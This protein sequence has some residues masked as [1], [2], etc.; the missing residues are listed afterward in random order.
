MPYNELQSIKNYRQNDIWSGIPAKTDVENQ[1]WYQVVKAIDIR[2]S[3]VQKSCENLVG[4]IGYACDEGVRRNNG[5]VGAVDGPEAIRERLAHLAFH[6]DGKSIADYGDIT[7]L[8]NDLEAAQD[9]LKQL[10]S[11]LI[12]EKIHPIILGG[13]HGIAFGHY[14][15]LHD[16]S[17]DADIGIINFDAHLDLRTPN[18][19]GNSGTP[20]NQIYE[21]T[22]MK[23]KGLNYMPIGI[24]AYS[25]A[26]T[27]FA[28]AEEIGAHII[29]L[30]EI[31]ASNSNVLEKRIRNF[32][33][34]NDYVYITIDL[35]GIS[36]AYAPGV[37][38][39]SPFGLQPDWI[40]DTLGLIFSSGKVISC[41]FAEMNPRYDIDK[42]TA[43]LAAELVTR[44]AGL[45]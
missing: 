15:G 21:L 35:D 23:G 30:D 7:C 12:I 20:F 2:K 8:G 14:Q 31:R 19:R 32:I 45:W 16:A 25:N 42:R 36:S 1:Y 43:K 5:R 37:S 6:I 24:Q 27:L 40:Y 34:L 38:A 18:P 28:K 33:D 17:P 10:V 26:K 39:P 9:S 22:Q 44:I 29:Y 4:L 13:G 3:A 41:D 11:S